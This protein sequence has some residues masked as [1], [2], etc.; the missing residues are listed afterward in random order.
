VNK[1]ALRNVLKW[2]GLALALIGFILGRI[3]TNPNM[4]NAGRVLVWVGLVMVV[5]GI[6]ARLFISEP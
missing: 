2:G 5:G 1:Q 6:I 3:A 4:F